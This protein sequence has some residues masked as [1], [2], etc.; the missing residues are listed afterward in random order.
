MSIIVC[1]WSVFQRDLPNLIAVPALAVAMIMGGTFKARAQDQ[2]VPTPQQQTT[3]PAA[4]QP[5][6][7]TPATTPA[8]TLAPSEQQISAPGAPIE[9]CCRKSWCAPSKISRRAKP[10]AAKPQPEAPPA[11]ATTAAQTALDAK[12]QE[13]NEARD[14]NLLTKLGASTHEHQPHDDRAAAASRQ[15][16]D[17]QAH[18]AIPRRVLRFGRLQSQLSHPRRIR[19]RADQDQWRRRSRR[20]FRPRRLSRHQFHRQYL[21][22]HRR[23]AGGIRAAHRRR[24]RHHQPEFFRHRAAKSVSMAAAG[25]RLRRASITA[26]AS[27]IR[28]ISSPRAAIWNGLGIE[29]PTP[30]LNAIHDQTQ[31]GK[32][33]GYASTMLDESTRF[34]V[35]SAASYSQFQIPSNPGQTPMGDFPAPTAQFH[36]RTRK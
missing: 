12:T 19:Q 22:P 16:A 8:A 13:F 1:R 36:G 3:V 23:A 24:A 20:R 6:A 29:N 14:N 32:F 2:Q 35:I 7:P 15:H 26:A 25:R 9:R 10:V 33:F 28:N 11:D 27:A 31:Q 5:A 30:T 34:S 18:F 4:S 17:R 21:A